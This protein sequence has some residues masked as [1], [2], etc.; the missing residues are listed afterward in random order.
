MTHSTFTI[1]S[2]GGNVWGGGSGR[3]S[4]MGGKRIGGKTGARGFIFFYS[5]KYT[6][7]LSR[8]TLKVTYNSNSTIKLDSHLKTRQGIQISHLLVKR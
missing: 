6:C 7:P 4:G 1:G 8:D 5:E 3:H 2:E